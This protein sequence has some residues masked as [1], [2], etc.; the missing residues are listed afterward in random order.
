MR[1]ISSYLPVE[2]L[3]GTPVV[4]RVKYLR[5][6]ALER[7]FRASGARQRD[8]FLDENAQIGRNQ[9]AVT[10]AFNMP[11]VIEL[12]LR[13]A[14]LNMP[15]ASVIV[16]DNSSKDE[17]RTEIAALCRSFGVAY[18]GLPRNPEWHPNR[19]HGIA[20]NWAY[21]N[22]VRAL[23]PDVFAFLDHD[24]F[25]L[26]PFDLAAKVS[27]QPVY[28]IRM[29][30]VE[31][32]PWSLW[33]GYSIFDYTA[34][35]MRD[36]DFN[37]ERPLRLDTGGYNWLRLY[38]YLDRDSLDYAGKCRATFRDSQDDDEHYCDLN[39]TFAHVGGASYKPAG[40]DAQRIA[41]FQRLVADIEQGGRW[42]DWLS[43]EANR[44]ASIVGSGS[45]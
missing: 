38:R 22:L 3:A 14:R 45:R 44:P 17:A 36:L 8:R 11:W 12:F 4:H 32:G 7:V 29:G 33:A 16:A 31:N 20:M 43:S 24:M 28:G 40:R 19:S 13:T 5:N 9:L 2:W 42:R 21:H 25:A 39:D 6:R 23:D 1:D 10:I 34:V 37:Y 18:V 27:R 41:F 15:D 26:D 30:D 35:K